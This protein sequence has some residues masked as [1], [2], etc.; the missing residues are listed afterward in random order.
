M[1]RDDHHGFPA[2]FAPDDRAAAEVDERDPSAVCDRLGVSRTRWLDVQHVKTID[3]FEADIAR[4]AGGEAASDRGRRPGDLHEVRHRERAQALD[5]DEF[6]RQ[7]SD[8]ALAAAAERFGSLPAAARTR[9]RPAVERS[10][11]GA[12]ILTSPR[13]CDERGIAANSWPSLPACDVEMPPGLSRSRR[14]DAA[15]D[16]MTAG[17]DSRSGSRTRC[18]RGGPRRPSS[19]CCRLVSADGGTGQAVPPDGALGAPSEPRRIDWRRI[20]GAASRQPTPVT[21]DAW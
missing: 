20:G 21:G 3:Q 1:P 11:R 12:G 2:D 9:S 14:C 15:A 7:L 17:G 16:A 8:S 19:D 4:G 13:A 10:V 18:C 5:H 6:S